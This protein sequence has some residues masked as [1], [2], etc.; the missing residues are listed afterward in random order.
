[1]KSRFACL[2][3]AMCAGAGLFVTAP[4][5]DASVPV[6]ISIGAPP[7]PVI[8]FHEEPRWVMV[9]GSRVYMVEEEDQ[10]AYD[11]F[12]YGGWYFI[13]NDGY[14]YRSTRWSGPFMAVRERFVPRPIMLVPSERW[15]QHPH[16]MPPGLAKKMYRDDWGGGPGRGRGHGRGHGRDRD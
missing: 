12:R 14:W 9:P 6:T 7:P 16:G 3:L 15:H 2:V 1:M 4:R 13:Y 10:P 11:V 5:V 8:V